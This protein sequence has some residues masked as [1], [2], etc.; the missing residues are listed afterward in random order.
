MHSFVAL[1]EGKHPTKTHRNEDWPS[2]SDALLA[3]T[4]LCSE[5]EDF[6]GV[7][8]S[9]TGYL[10]W[11]AKD[12]MLNN[13]N[14]KLPC[15]YCPVGTKKHRSLWPTNFSSSNTWKDVGVV[16]S[17]F[18]TFPFLVRSNC[19]VVLRCFELFFLLFKEGC[20]PM[21]PRG[22]CILDILL[23]CDLE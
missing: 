2:A 3:D 12:L 23:S 9:I 8:W 14:S 11:Y 19:S 16:S 15:P 7:I 1:F 17:M 21:V 6:F 22:P 18:L 5:L 20:F 4:W 10:D 13:Y